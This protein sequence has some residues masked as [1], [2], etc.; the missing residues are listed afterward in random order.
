TMMRTSEWDTRSRRNA[1]WVL[2][3]G[4][5]V[6]HQA[7]EAFLQHMGVD[8]RRGDVG[9]AEQGLYHAQ[10]GAVVQEMARERV[11]QH[12]RTHLRRAQSGGACER[13]ELARELLAGQMPGLAERRE[14][15]F[16]LL[17]AA[18]LEQQRQVLAHRGL[19]RVVER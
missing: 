4:V 6:A 12:V 18:L 16:A 14:Q 17:V 5:Q 11:P 19:G 7:L 2:A 8:L 15:P 9:V 10:V 13:L 1:L 3:Q